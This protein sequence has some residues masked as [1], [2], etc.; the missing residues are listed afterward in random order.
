MAVWR[1]V[2]NRDVIG[3]TRQLG[4]VFVCGVG[5]RDIVENGMSIGYCRHFVGPR[6]PGNANRTLG[7]HASV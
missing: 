2:K 6:S 1:E 3:K 7:L 4:T 5:A